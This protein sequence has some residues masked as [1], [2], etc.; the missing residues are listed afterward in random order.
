MTPSSTQHP[1][2]SDHLI[3]LRE[4]MPNSC[5]DPKIYI[6]TQ[7]LA[8]MMCDYGF[9]RMLNR[10]RESSFQVSETGSSPDLI[11]EVSKIA[12]ELLKS[13]PLHPDKR[14]LTENPDWIRGLFIEINVKL[15]GHIQKNQ[16]ENNK[17]FDAFHYRIREEITTQTNSSPLETEHI[18][19]IGDPILEL[20]NRK[21]KESEAALELFQSENSGI[22]S[23]A[24]LSDGKEEKKLTQARNSALYMRDLFQLVTRSHRPR[25][26]PQYGR[27]S[28]LPD[29]SPM[30]AQARRREFHRFN[31]AKTR[32]AFEEERSKERETPERE[33]TSPDRDLI[34][35]N[36]FLT[37]SFS[38][39]NP[40]IAPS[41]RRR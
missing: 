22:F 3:F 33:R 40:F 37:A 30:A 38:S 17:W 6:K 1:A 27:P 14:L 15:K 12:Q 28:E 24:C 2:Q 9:S 36:Q 18:N 31:L 23:C 39:E 32:Q 16:I 29:D 41:Q 21:I 8:G 25:R 7:I 10:F 34:S 19:R 5:K 35:G 13:P 11:E 4:V 20:Y 26:R